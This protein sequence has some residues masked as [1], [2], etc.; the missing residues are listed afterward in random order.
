M[1]K[2]FRKNKRSKKNT[3]CPMKPWRSRGFSLIETLVYIAIFTM[4]S[5]VV[6][7]ALIVMIKSFR[8]TAVEADFLQNAELFERMSREIRQAKSINV[9]SVFGSSPGDLKLNSTDSSGVAK[10]VEFLL[11]GQNLQF[12][13]NGVLTGNL[14]TSN[15]QITSLIFRQITTAKG[16]AIKIEMSVKDTRDKAGRTENFY[17]TIEM[18]GSYVP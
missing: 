10:T 14:N 8:Q 11:S 16:K 2:F 3:A 15:I 17:D 7:N 6:I 4:L 13:E 18:R 12:K 1:I 5:I 9:T